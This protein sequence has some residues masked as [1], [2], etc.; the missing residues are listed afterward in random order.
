M[1]DEPQ[2]PQVPPWRRTSLL[3]DGDV[4]LS[5]LMA[6]EPRISVHPVPFMSSCIFLRKKFFFYSWKILTSL[7]GGYTL[8]SAFDYPWALT[9]KQPTYCN[10]IS[11]PLLLFYLTYHTPS[12]SISAVGS[13][14]LCFV[15]L[16]YVC[17]CT[18]VSCI[19]LIFLYNRLENT[20]PFVLPYC[21]SFNP[22]DF[23]KYVFKFNN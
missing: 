1:G 3:G 19:R 15:S 20:V 18:L 22:N 4:P 9:I 11:P 16:I 23:N 2:E 17:A 5:R 7:Q 6:L 14:A 8:H 21:F 12:A 13:W 10:H